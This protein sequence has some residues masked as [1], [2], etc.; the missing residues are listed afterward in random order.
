MYCVTAEDVRSS[1]AVAFQETA[2]KTKPGGA[3]LFLGYNH[4][5]KALRGKRF[6]IYC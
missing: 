3:V 2:E 5:I 1:L 6:I 4:I